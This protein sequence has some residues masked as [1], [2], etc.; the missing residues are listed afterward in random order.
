M[1]IA[2]LDEYVVFYERILLM[3]DL[4]HL[5]A[6]LHNNLKSIYLITC[7]VDH[8][9]YHNSEHA[10]TMGGVSGVT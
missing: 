7:R 2:D 4:V 5:S 3:L 10:N 6:L 9:L 8:C 1:T